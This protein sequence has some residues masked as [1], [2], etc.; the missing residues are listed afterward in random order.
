M[1]TVAAKTCVCR[2][3][4]TAPC[5]NLADITAIDFESWGYD[6]RGFVRCPTCM[7]CGVTAE[8]PAAKD[9]LGLFEERAA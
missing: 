6:T 1:T 7:E 5:P 2:R 9:Q 3:T 8:P 4:V